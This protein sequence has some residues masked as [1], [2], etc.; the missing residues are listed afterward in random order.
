MQ[1]LFLTTGLE[2]WLLET[3]AGLRYR[4][5]YEGLSDPAKA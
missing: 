2:G 5:S 1:E 4:L 3:E